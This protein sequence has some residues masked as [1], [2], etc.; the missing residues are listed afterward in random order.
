M[1][2][3]NQPIRKDQSPMKPH[4]QVENRGPSDIESAEVYILFLTFFIYFKKRFTSFFINYLYLKKVY[5]HFYLLFIL[6]KGLHPV[7]VSSRA[8][9]APALPHRAAC[10]GRPWEL[11]LC[12]R[13]QH[14][15]HQGQLHI[16]CFRVR[17]QLSATKVHIYPG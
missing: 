17:L 5:I 2:L 10:G 14:S 4:R 6:K 3:H 16:I 7:A 13:C 12:L 9:A 15:K 1:K 11:S 8:G